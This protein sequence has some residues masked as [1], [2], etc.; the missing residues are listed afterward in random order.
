MASQ[1]G[2]KSQRFN[3]SFKVP[4]KFLKGVI[5]VGGENIKRINSEVG[6]GCFIKGTQVSDTEAQFDVSAY[7]Q[8]AVRL[9][10]NKIR[11]LLISLSQK[12]TQQVSVSVEVR[13]DAVPYIIG[14]KGVH[15][16]SI[17]REAGTG[18][19]IIY[20]N[21]AFHITATSDD[22]AE[23][24][25][26]IILNEEA[27]YIAKVSRALQPRVDEKP[28]S[29]NPFS[30]LVVE[31]VV[32]EANKSNID[33]HLASH[34][35]NVKKAVTNKRSKKTKRVPIEIT[36]KPVSDV[37]RL[38]NDIRYEVAKRLELTQDSDENRID[39]K[40]IEMFDREVRRF[41]Q[42]NPRNQKPLFENLVE[43]VYKRKTSSGETQQAS[44]D[45]ESLSGDD[46]P[47][48]ITT[49]TTT[50]ITGPWDDCMR[51]KDMKIGVAN[52]KEFTVSETVLNRHK[53]WDRLDRE[54]TE[55][56]NKIKSTKI[57]LDRVIELQ[58]ID[59]D[60]EIDL[61]FDFDEDHD[62]DHD[63][64]DYNDILNEY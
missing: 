44:S 62:E 31:N 61:D 9:A 39:Y 30:A 23:K 49:K 12:K 64:Y 56:M 22:S 18:T 54:Y 63:D 11:E 17:A 55:L 25:Q 2:V 37:L 35:A 27:R 59:V 13:A 51:V 52:A 33:Q 24:A 6:A 46:F 21:N 7:S 4:I 50:T 57:T 42:Y 48:T 29:T 16:K 41:N 32:T 36:L 20:N 60:V 40:K 3:G 8:E 45:I 10:A 26:Q 14:N 19:F 58:D 15:I 5:G 43:K 1:Q 47:M 38:K 34:F 53:E 28:V